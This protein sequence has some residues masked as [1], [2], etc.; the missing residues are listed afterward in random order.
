[1]RERL[2]KS[3]YTCGYGHIGD[4]NIHINS[5]LYDRSKKSET[6]KL[7]EPYIFE[8]LQKCKGSI[9]AEHGVGVMKA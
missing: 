2:G 5:C 9:S 3:C 4:G 6:E 7:L 8:Y 1:V